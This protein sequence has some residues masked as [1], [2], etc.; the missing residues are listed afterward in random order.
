M[1]KRIFAL[2][3]GTRSVTGIILQKQENTYTVCDF[4]VEEHRERSMLDGLI[5]NVRA[6]AD[7]IT[8]VK[9]A[10]EKKYSTPA[11][12]RV[13]TAASSLTTKRAKATIQLDHQPIT[14]E[15]TVKHLELS[16]VQ[17][18]QFNLAQE[19]EQ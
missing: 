6:V 4:H 2:D 11:T 5:H 17:S 10:L 13:T 9:S 14:K 16:A 19:N 3:I 1:K 8:N 7:V 18:A 12:V 15:Q